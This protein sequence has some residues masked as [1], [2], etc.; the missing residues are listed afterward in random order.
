VSKKKNCISIEVDDDQKVTIVAE[1]TT[2]INENENG[3]QIFNNLPKKF[4]CIIGLPKR[5]VAVS[6]NDFLIYTIHDSFLK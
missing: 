2:D 1:I 3:A 5:Y 4:E 6:M